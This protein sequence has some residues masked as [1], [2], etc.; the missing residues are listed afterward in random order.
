MCLFCSLRKGKFIHSRG[1]G[2]KGIS[3]VCSTLNRADIPKTRSCFA[4]SSSQQHCLVTF[5]KQIVRNSNHYMCWCAFGLH[6]SYFFIYFL[7]FTVYAVRT[8]EWHI[9]SVGTYPRHMPS[10][11]AYAEPLIHMENI[12][13]VCLWIS[14]FSSCPLL[15]VQHT[16]F[17]VIQMASG[18]N[19][20]DSTH[21]KSDSQ[22]Q[23]LTHQTQHGQWFYIC[24][25]IGSMWNGSIYLFF[26][27]FHW[28]MCYIV[29]E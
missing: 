21:N 11:F 12:P 15:P 10:I 29:R 20:I 13:L 1:R 6:N 14:L 7:H 4:W 23:M 16:M 5:P 2:R 22:R 27:I 25:S 18:S 17:S 28:L 8:P 26:F 9:F 19:H 3:A 24:Q